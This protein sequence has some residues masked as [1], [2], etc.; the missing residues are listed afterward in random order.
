[1]NIEEWWPKLQPATREWLLANN[2]A[3]IAARV[4]AELIKAGRAASRGQLSDD[5]IDWIEA[6]A[7]D[8][9]PGE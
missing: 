9:E 7:N 4:A 6:F 3:E 1:M 5:E 8:E 2:G